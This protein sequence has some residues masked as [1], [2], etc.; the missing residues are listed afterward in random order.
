MLTR[1]KNARYVQ[2][3]PVVYFTKLYIEMKL[4]EMIAR[5][6]RSANEM[7]TVSVTAI[8]SVRSQE[9][10]DVATMVVEDDDEWVYPRRVPPRS[11]RR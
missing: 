9:D 5:I 1:A 10:F 7:N 2:F 8:A 6:V 11:F 3:N 4:A